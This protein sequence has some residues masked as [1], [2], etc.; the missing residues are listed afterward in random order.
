MPN[1]KKSWN[2]LICFF[3]TQN[4]FDL[5]HICILKVFPISFCGVI[6]NFQLICYFNIV[7]CHLNISNLEQCHFIEQRNIKRSMVEGQAI[8]YLMRKF[9]FQSTLHKIFI[10]SKIFLWH[11]KCE[12]CDNGAFI[13]F[14]LYSF[15]CRFSFVQK[16]D[17]SNG[18][19]CKWKLHIYIICI[20]TY[21]LK[22]NC[23]SLQE[24]RCEE[25]N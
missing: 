7:R 22:W 2:I 3:W 17:I 15:V 8:S 12:K 1:A 20:P 19:L 6:R 18:I 24:K 23:L 11:K 25:K 14:N 10:K 13:V 16:W 4:G 21:N 5:Q 9:L